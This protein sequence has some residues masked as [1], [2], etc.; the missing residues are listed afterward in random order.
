MCG[1][2]K[3]QSEKNQ[4]EKNPNRNR[5]TSA[6]RS[7]F[8]PCYFIVRYLPWS[9]QLFECVQAEMYE[10]YPNDRGSHHHHHS[11][12]GEQTTAIRML[13]E[14]EI[15]LMMPSIVLW[16]VVSDMC[17]LRPDSTTKKILKF[18]SNCLSP[19]MTIVITIMARAIVSVGSFHFWV[20]LLEIKSG[21]F[22]PTVDRRNHYRFPHF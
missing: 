8:N 19:I 18:L 3:K 15:S 12:H 11:R 4:V 13:S 17:K 14:N 10:N 7:T 20:E 2:K 1:K 5:S 21:S 9:I 22:Y 6:T 16:P